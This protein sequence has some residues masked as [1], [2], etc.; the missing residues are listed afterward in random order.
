VLEDA[1]K[2]TTVTTTRTR[3]ALT[4]VLAATLVAVPGVANA[5]TSMYSTSGRS[6]VWYDDSGNRVVVCDMVNNDGIGAYIYWS[7]GFEVIAYNGCETRR[8]DDGYYTT[9]QVW[10][11]VH[12]NGQRVGRHGSEVRGF[13]T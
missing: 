1:S 9:V 11:W 7:G 2:G 6:H 10:D 4:G 5:D 8:V 13:Y 12:V 3:L